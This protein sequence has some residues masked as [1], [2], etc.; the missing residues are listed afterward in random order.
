MESSGQQG[1]GAQQLGLT[2]FGLGLLADVPLPGAWETRRLREP[3]LQIRSVTAQA[4]ENSWSGLEAIGWEAVVDGAP[5]IV[6]RGIDGDHRFV[7]GAHPDRSGARSD[8][9]RAV[10][11]LCAEASVLQCARSD[12][13]EPSWWRVV[14]DI[15]ASK[16]HL[17]AESLTVERSR[18]GLSASRR[19]SAVARRVPDLQR[20]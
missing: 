4:I 13:A 2:A 19:C 18:R 9:A 10:H 3:S 6:E 11:H 12:P 8:G 7:H 15:P 5:F 20:Q 14:L 16:I 17:A 1:G